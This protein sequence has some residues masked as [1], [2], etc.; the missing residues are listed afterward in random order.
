MENKRGRLEGSSAIFQCSFNVQESHE[1][2][3]GSNALILYLL[4][5]VD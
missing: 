2:D 3:S 5:F 4:I 1:Q